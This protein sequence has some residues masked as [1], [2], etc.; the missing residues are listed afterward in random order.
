[1][2]LV[3]AQRAWAST[4]RA[5]R[6]SGR[7]GCFLACLLEMSVADADF[8]RRVPRERRVR[9]ASVATLGPQAPPGSR[10]SRAWP[11]KKAR[12]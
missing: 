2:G 4:A 11:G 12:R 5:V 1:M 7:E 3:G 6:G 10:G 9:W 8:P